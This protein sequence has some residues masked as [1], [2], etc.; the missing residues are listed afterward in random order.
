M[1][2]PP[3]IQKTWR[4]SRS[5]E[6]PVADAFSDEMDDEQDQG[7]S[8]DRRLICPSS[9][10][11]VFGRVREMT[12]RGGPTFPAGPIHL[13]YGIHFGANRGFGF[14]HIWA[15]HFRH[16]KDHDQAMSQ[17]IAEVAKILQPTTEVFYLPPKVKEKNKK[18]PER[19]KVFRLSAGLVII[20]LRPEHPAFYSVVTGGFNPGEKKMGSLIGALE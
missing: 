11:D 2:S 12:V 1:T 14:Q 8:E 4:R 20:E 13:H 19:A 9:K 3:V 16:V 17:I 18:Q 7:P 6:T 10:T 15:E 5:Y